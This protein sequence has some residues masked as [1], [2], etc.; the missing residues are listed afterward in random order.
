MSLLNLRRPK[1]VVIKEMTSASGKYKLFYGHHFNRGKTCFDVSTINQTNGQI[2]TRHYIEGDL[3][4]SKAEALR[5]YH[6]MEKGMSRKPDYEEQ[7]ENDPRKADA[8]RRALTQRS[9]K[10]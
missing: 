1:C 10:T 8:F 6:E 5:I 9:G 4:N 2:V 3:V 7:E